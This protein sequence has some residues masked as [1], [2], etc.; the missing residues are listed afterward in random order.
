MDSGL[1]KHRREQAEP[2]ATA[3]GDGRVL[4]EVRL[5]GERDGQSV[6][7]DGGLQRNMSIKSPT[8]ATVASL[9]SICK[10]CISVEISVELPDFTSLHLHCLL[11]LCLSKSLVTAIL[12]AISNQRSTKTQHSAFQPAQRSID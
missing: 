6:G 4:A 9:P 10:T 7:S 5:P 2:R 3:D 1:S 11:S 8:T 12:S